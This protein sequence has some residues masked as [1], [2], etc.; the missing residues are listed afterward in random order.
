MYVAT[1][2]SLFTTPPFDLPN[3]L[4]WGANILVDNKGCITMF[5]LV[6]QNKLDK[7]IGVLLDIDFTIISIKIGKTKKKGYKIVK[8]AKIVIDTSI[9]EVVSM[10]IVTNLPN[11][12]T[13][14]P[15]DN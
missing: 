6:K 15:N 8:V 14:Y 10:E 1:L 12:Q 9:Y 5:G 7:T 11:M 2:L 3:S 4:C 13:A